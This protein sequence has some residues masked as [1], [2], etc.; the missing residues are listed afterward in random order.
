MI[1]NYLNKLIYAIGIKKLNCD[2]G[3]NSALCRR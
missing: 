1:I 2:H 3:P